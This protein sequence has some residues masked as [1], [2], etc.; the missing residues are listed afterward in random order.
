LLL[1]DGYSFRRIANAL[2]RSV[3]TISDEINLGSVGGKYDPKKAHHKAYVRRKSARF[4]G[5]KIIA[6][7][8]LRDSVE[9]KLLEGRSPQ[10]IAGRITNREV[11]LPSISADSILRFL[12]SPHG[13]VIEY[14]RAQL[15][16]AQK[17]KR[18]SKRKL[19]AKLSERTFID[20]RPVV[21]NERS[22]VGDIEADFIV[23]GKDG[24]GIL[25]TVAD[26]KLRVGF[27]EKILPVTIPNV[28]RAFLRIQKRFPEMC[29][30]TTDNDILFRHHQ[31]LARLLG[32]PIYFCHPYHSWEKGTIENINGEIRKHIPKGND[33]SRY[34]RPF[35]RRVEQ[36][37]NDRYLALLDYATPQ[38][39]LDS[40][41][42]NNPTNNNTSSETNNKKRA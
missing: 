28:H 7:S 40:Y 20:D 4:Q 17:R 8:A 36:K 38:E 19:T 33:I 14:E 34:S 25:L 37:I 10:S 5:R 32:V 42:K 9:V 41:R 26:R 29:S 18:R 13:R 23:S 22:R 16:K 35:I 21:I 11:D 30:I 24:S 31:E 27:I 6:H 1:K 3:S 12:A 15:K 39:V 2:G